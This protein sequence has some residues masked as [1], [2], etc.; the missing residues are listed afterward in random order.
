MMKTAEWRLAL[1]AGD[2]L[3]VALSAFQTLLCKRTFGIHKLV[4]AVAEFIASQLGELS[5]AQ[6]LAALDVAG[7][8][9]ATVPHR[10]IVVVFDGCDPEIALYSMS[11]QLDKTY[12]NG[13][14]QSI[15]M[16]TGQATRALELIRDSKVSGAFLVIQHCHKEPDF[17][18][19]LEYECEALA[20][21]PHN[22]HQEFRLWLTTV[23]GDLS[24]QT[25]GGVFG[26]CLK[27][28]L[29]PPSCLRASLAA[30]LTA[31]HR[32]PSLC[33]TVHKDL[34]NARFDQ[35]RI[36]L[37]V[38]HGLL[39]EHC[40]HTA[41]TWSAPHHFV[42]HAN[43]DLNLQQLCSVAISDSAS[44]FPLSPRNGLG[45][46]GSNISHSEDDTLQSNQSNRNVFLRYKSTSSSDQQDT[47]ILFEQ[48]RHNGYAGL[49]NHQS[50][51]ETLS[52]LVADGTYGESTLAAI[53]YQKL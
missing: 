6:G 18:P 7:P 46:I 14:F 37:T 31:H 13:E 11:K 28:V 21:Y 29:E 50:I 49:Q 42:Q 30:H 38:V 44:E 40:R 10:P 36:G 4:G 3:P 8:D 23:P 45:R 27:V 53:C 41:G 48:L 25:S 47:K 33:C 16:G 17:L 12:D 32:D 2:A 19:Q 52:Y 5:I 35:M 24:L 34:N 9:D 43:L 51:L 26:L 15:S 20:D 1:D 39:Q 22:C